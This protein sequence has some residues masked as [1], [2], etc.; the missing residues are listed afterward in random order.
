VD[1]LVPNTRIVH[2]KDKVVWET[3][4]L[5]DKLTLREEMSSE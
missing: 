2:I 3:A 5:R 4:I 1:F